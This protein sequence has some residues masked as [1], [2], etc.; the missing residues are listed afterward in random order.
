MKRHFFLLLPLVLCAVRADVPDYV[1]TFWEANYDVLNEKIATFDSLQ[2]V[3]RDIHEATLTPHAHPMAHILDADRNPYDI[4]VRRTE[5][6]IE[7]L[8][9]MPGGTDLAAIESE[10]QG[11]KGRSGSKEDYLEVCALRR[12]VALM[13][14]L[15]DFDEILYVEAYGGCN[16][17]Q[18]NA[19]CNKRE[20]GG[21]LFTVSGFKTG[22]PVV[23]DILADS[24]FE[25]GVFEGRTVGD[26][27]ASDGGRFHSPDVSFDATKIV[28]AFG[29]EDPNRGDSCFFKLFSVNADGSRLRQLTFEDPEA[30]Y[31]RGNDY[32]PCWL[33]NGRIAF[34]SERVG[35]FV[36]CHGGGFAEQLRGNLFSMKEDG[37]DVVRLSFHETDDLFPSVDNNGRIVY[38]RWDYVDRDFNA[39]HHIWYCDPDGCDPR[40]PHGNYAYPHFSRFNATDEEFRPVVHGRRYNTSGPYY[41]DTYFRNRPW[42][43]QCIRAVPGSHKYVAVA[44]GH[45]TRPIG[46]L[47]LIDTYIEDDNGMAQIQRVTNPDFNFFMDQGDQFP[48]VWNVNHVDQYHYLTTPWPL[49]EE[50][51]IAPVG[52]GKNVKEVLLVDAFGNRVAL[53]AGKDLPARHTVP[54]R[55]RP[56]PPVIPTKTFQGERSG[57]PEHKR[58]VISIQNV[59]VADIPFPEG[60][61]ITR[62]RV[63]QAIPRP[64]QFPNKREPYIGWCHG[65]LN[66]MSLGTVPVESDGSAYFEAPVGKEIYFQVLD[67]RGIAVQSMRSGTYVHK[68]EHLSC[69]GCHENK[70]ETPPSMEGTPLAFQRDPSPLTPDPQGS[71][72]LTFARLAA[73]VLH[74]TCDPCHASATTGDPPRF[75]IPATQ[76][77]TCSNLGDFSCGVLYHKLV[78]DYNLHEICYSGGKG[79]HGGTEGFRSKPGGIGTL[80]SDL[81]TILMA[82]K[83]RQRV[84]EGH[85]SKEDLYRITTWL[86]LT[87]PEFSAHYDLEKQRAGVVVWP[88]ID[89]D[90]ENPT[91]VESDRPSRGTTTVLRELRDRG[92]PTSEMVHSGFTMSIRGLRAVVVNPR[93]EQ[94]RMSLFNAAGQIVGT[95]IM[96]G[97]QARILIDFSGMVDGSGLYY[98]RIASG[99]YS[100]TRRAVFYRQ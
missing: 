88:M 42:S 64:E 74:N 95:R 28:F 76:A 80:G 79:R 23:K 82:D 11:L 2:S 78:K 7:H 70:W 47:V 87:A 55:P 39:A 6:L 43:E 30:R 48:S 35:G 44:S 66:R 65:Q 59:Y 31:P 5:A 15:L 26:V 67:E 75:N 45:H 58:A 18:C 96:S 81:G 97:S 46:D 3:E 98:V 17:I 99:T 68:G 14:P 53:F 90:P 24:R 41:R 49:S 36:R 40:A 91:G 93:K 38:T 16:I 84:S 100:E 52:S 21:G 94:V 86:D 61:N 32:H 13:N 20:A 50:F 19:V 62:L 83:H 71:C 51:F 34:I 54:L 63:V 12:R 57:L 56:T 77:G 1:R 8:K 10:F 29:A 9:L 60:T 22:D 73:P 69:V 4:V 27:V 25:N 85:L 92:Y 89:V 37:S 33:P 72:P